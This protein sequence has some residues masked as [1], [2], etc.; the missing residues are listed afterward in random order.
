MS[1]AGGACA[2]VC[3]HPLRLGLEQRERRHR[4]PALLDRHA[5]QQLHVGAQY[6]LDAQSARTGSSSAVARAGLPAVI[7]I[8]AAATVRPIA[9]SRSG[10]S[11]AARAS[12]V[13]AVAGAPRRAAS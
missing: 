1:S 12:A 13:A 3:D 9:R 2:V 10:L 6:R 8:A 7:A 11:S 5:A 4:A